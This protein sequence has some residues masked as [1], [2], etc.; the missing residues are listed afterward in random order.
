LLLDALVEKVLISAYV[1]VEISRYLSMADETR[2]KSAQKA[3]AK[4]KG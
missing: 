1:R 2:V 3:I 4:V